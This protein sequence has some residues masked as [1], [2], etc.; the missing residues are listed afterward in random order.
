[1]DE[2]SK[3]YVGLDVHKESIAIAQAA[4]GLEPAR[5]LGE[6]AHVMD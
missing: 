1:M 3:V 5:L 6:I 2:M 4:P